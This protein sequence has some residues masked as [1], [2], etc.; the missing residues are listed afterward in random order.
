MTKGVRDH[1]HK[2]VAILINRTP[3]KQTLISLGEVERIAGMAITMKYTPMGIELRL[4]T[5]EE[6][7]RLAKQEGG[8]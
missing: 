7:E 1:W 2:L 5:M 6:G 4:V 3:H 8:L